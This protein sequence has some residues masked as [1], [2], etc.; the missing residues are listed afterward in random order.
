V[1]LG[2]GGEAREVREQERLCCQ[3]RPLCHRSPQPQSPPGHRTTIVACPSQH[4]ADTITTGPVA[5]FLV[6]DI[7]DATAELRSA[8]VE[9]L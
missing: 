5:G 8:G 2:Q 6:D 9:I 1:G 3:V 7:Q 4:A